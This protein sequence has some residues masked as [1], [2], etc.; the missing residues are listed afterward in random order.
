[1]RMKTNSTLNHQA[2]IS[3]FLLFLA[4]SKYDLLKMSL[5]YENGLRGQG[6]PLVVFGHENVIVH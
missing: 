2:K 3:D 6:V 1:M 5:L 4:N